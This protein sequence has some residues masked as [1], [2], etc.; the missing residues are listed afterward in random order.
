M[1]NYQFRSQNPPQPGSIVTIHDDKFSHENE[2]P[3]DLLYKG[4]AAKVIKTINLYQSRSECP[5]ITVSKVV[6]K[7]GKT[8][9]FPVT[10]IN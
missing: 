9:A 6:L 4:Q 5:P 2:V 10:N 3:S 8:E 7:N 1:G